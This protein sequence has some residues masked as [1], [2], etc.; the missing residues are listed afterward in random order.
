MLCKYKLR[1]I[2]VLFDDEDIANK[3]NSLSQHDK[4]CRVV[5]S[6]ISYQLSQLLYFS[7]TNITIMIYGVSFSVCPDFTIQ[8]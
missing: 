8:V 3:K 1:N 5:A 2:T 6:T 4:T 7:F